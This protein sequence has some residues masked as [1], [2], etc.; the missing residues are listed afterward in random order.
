VGRLGCYFGTA[1]IRINPA[2]PGCQTVPASLAP[3]G[4]NA[5]AGASDAPLTR[6][7]RAFAGA[8][9]VT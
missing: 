8:L 6:Q 7:V 1:Q 5:T 9:S 2:P 4:E 3:S